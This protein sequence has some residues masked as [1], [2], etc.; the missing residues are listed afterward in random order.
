MTKYIALL[1]LKGGAGKST[2]TANLCGY[3]LSQNA[4]VLT[5]DADI[6]QGTLS[7]W[8]SLT[9]ESENH[10]HAN[11]LNTRKN[12]LYRR[13]SLINKGLKPHKKIYSI[14][15]IADFDNIFTHN[16]ITLRTF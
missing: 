6:P 15:P 2:I 12:Y 8:A 10:H 3:L 5:V 1:Q 9:S 4:T 7:A 16:F 14:C 13:E 11:Y